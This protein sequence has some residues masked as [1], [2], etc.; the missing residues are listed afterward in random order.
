MRCISTNSFLPRPAK[1]E[2]SLRAPAEESSMAE[3]DLELVNSQSLPWK[4]E[5]GD[6]P[7]V[8]HPPLAVILDEE[9]KKIPLELQ[10]NERQMFL[11]CWLL[12]LGATSSLSPNTV[13]NLNKGWICSWR[14]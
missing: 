12:L 5:E 7:P 4:E 14:L 10:L 11:T 2:A 1:E 6:C 13:K 8:T 3:P 9:E